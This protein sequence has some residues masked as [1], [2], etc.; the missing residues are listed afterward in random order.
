MTKSMSLLGVT[1]FGSSLLHYFFEHQQGLWNSLILQPKAFVR[2]AHHNH[3][4]GGSALGGR[5]VPLD[6]HERNSA[7]MI[8]PQIV[9]VVILLVEEILH[10]LRWPKHGVLPQYQNSLGHPGGA[11]FLPSIVVN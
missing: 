2:R 5:G 3:N 6:S 11:E 7:W 4:L 8:V 10:H 9:L 1:I